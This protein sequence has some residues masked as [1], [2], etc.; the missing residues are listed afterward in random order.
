MLN[1]WSVAAGEWLWNLQEL[2]KVLGK[3]EGVV[4]DVE[5]APV[6]SSPHHMAEKLQQSMQRAISD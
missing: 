6:A 5:R 3:L 1:I 2:S 4:V